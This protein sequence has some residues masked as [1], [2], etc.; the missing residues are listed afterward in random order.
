MPEI[1]K[2]HQ[3]VTFVGVTPLQYAL[4]DYMESAP[5]HYLELPGFYQ[6]KRDCCAIY[7]RIQSL[8]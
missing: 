7:W 1:L 5:E 2:V 3:Y 6:Q 4:A 8:S